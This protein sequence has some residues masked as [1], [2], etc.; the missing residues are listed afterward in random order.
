MKELHKPLNDG[1]IP[2]VEIANILFGDWIKKFDSN[3]PE[4]NEYNRLLTSV[5]GDKNGC[6]VNTYLF[7][8]SNVMLFKE[9][10]CDNYWTGDRYKET[11]KIVDY[12]P[13]LLI[14][15]LNDMGIF[16][17]VGIKLID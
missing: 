9:L 4:F 5:V 13:L 12:N 11:I 8:D 10:Y 1:R 14:K 2:L 16:T 6:G 15:K 3:I 7:F 17:N